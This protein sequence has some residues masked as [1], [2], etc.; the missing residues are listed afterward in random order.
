MI[1][2]LTLSGLQSKDVMGC[3]DKFAFCN[4]E[5]EPITPMSKSFESFLTLLSGY[6]L[7]KLMKGKVN[8]T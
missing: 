2:W 1:D 7:K 6:E 5:T 8:K 3:V 4:N